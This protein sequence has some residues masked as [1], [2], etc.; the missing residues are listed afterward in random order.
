MVEPVAHPHHQ[1][2]T[3]PRAAIAAAWDAR[4]DQGGEDAR[5]YVD[6]DKVEA[7]NGGA[8]AIC[9]FAE[10]CGGFKY[11]PVHGRLHKRSGQAARERTAEKGPH[12]SI[13]GRNGAE[14]AVEGVLWL[15]H[16]SV[17]DQA[18]AVD[19]FARH[20]SIEKLLRGT[21]NHSSVI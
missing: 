8:E 11:S 4:G 20:A 12:L 15:Q 5:R 19:V 2:R 10:D 3:P 13:P 6:P 17:E 21:F 16:V 18:D 14:I 1:P 7:G 9:E